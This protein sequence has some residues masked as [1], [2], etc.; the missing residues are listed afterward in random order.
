MLKIKNLIKKFDENIVL[1]NI[2]LEVNQGEVVSIIGP[3]GTGKSTLLRCINVLEEA[4][5]GKL[6]I[7]NI[8]V[9]LD[10]LTKKDILELRRK[11]AMVFQNYNLYN[12]KT[13]VQ[14]I[15][16]PLVVVK[17]LK[18]DEAMKIALDKLKMVG[19][20]DKKD[21][22]PSRLSGGQKQRVAIARA[23]AVNPEIILLDEPTSALDPELVGEVLEVIKSLANEHM[24][25]IIVTHEMNFAREVS[26]RIIFM[27][28]GKIVEQGSPQELF[29][30]DKNTRINEFAR[31][32]G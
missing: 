4:S 25:M 12:N 3:S 8:D 1:N 17:K 7:G 19:L 24:T 13:V 31:I 23:I 10:K 18:K 11:S 28:N 5:S 9:E 6:S 29:K 2:D 32:V 14:N 30:V 21:E 16:E 15:M 27:E 22:Y 20:Y 26:D